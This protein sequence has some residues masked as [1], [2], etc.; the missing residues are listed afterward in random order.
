MLEKGNYKTVFFGAH[1]LVIFV[2]VKH[3]KCF[4]TLPVVN[5]LNWWLYPLKKIK[6]IFFLTKNIFFNG[7]S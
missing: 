6:I 4:N 5:V 3:I 1:M 2:F 7:T